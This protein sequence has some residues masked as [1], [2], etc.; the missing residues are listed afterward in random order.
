MLT[1]DTVRAAVERLRRQGTD[2]AS[3]E[4]K[5]CAS[6][7]GQSVWESVSAFANTK[8]GLLVLGLNEKAG[9]ASVPSFEADAVLDAFIEGMGDGGAEGAKLVNA[10]RYEPLRVE[11]DGVLVLAI[12]VFENDL[13]RKPCYIAARGVLGGSYRRLDDRDVR[14]SATEVHELHASFVPSPAEREVVPEASLEDLDPALVDGLLARTARSKAMRG[15]ADRLEKLRNLNVVDAQGGVRLCGILSLGR[16]PQRFVPRALIDVAVHPGVQKAQVSGLRFIDRAL[17]EGPVGE[18]VDEACGAVLRNLRAASAVSGVGRTDV[19]EV[20]VEAVR[21]AVA[22]AVL[23]REYG[24]LFC[25]QAVSVDVYADRITVTSPGGLWGGKTLETLGDGV[26]R[27]RNPVLMRLMQDVPLPGGAGAIAEGQ[28]SGINMM[29]RAMAEAGL[30]APRFRVTYDQFVVELRRP[31]GPIAFVVPGG[32]P[33]AGALASP[34][35]E[36]DRGD[37]EGFATAGQGLSPQ[38]EGAMMH[39]L[40]GWGT[41]VRPG[42]AEHFLI[43]KDGWVLE[44]LSE[45]YAKGVHEIAAE[46]G[47]SL[48]VTRRALRE[49]AK[50]GKVVPTAPAT[51]RN[52]KYLLA[53]G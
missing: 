48:S 25:G 45:T 13:A 24:P 11:V 9:F 5:A 38:E 4:A 29:A 37:S 7:L 35:P 1:D 53:S 40:P 42:G 14:L 17:C 52:R 31:C 3:C 44:V 18:M 21:E 32:R 12:E 34:A 20:P 8:G 15:T 43:E 19:F 46:G 41:A 36:R 27:C 39:V 22:N 2:D 28:G 26:S 23:H 6:G 33:S 47:R 16:Y 51:S 50:A 10:P 30:P 49:L